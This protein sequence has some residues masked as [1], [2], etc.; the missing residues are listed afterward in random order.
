MKFRYNTTFTYEKSQCKGDDLD[1]SL[2]VKGELPQ[3]VEYLQFC[4]TIDKF[5]PV[6]H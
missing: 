6:L 4:S 3:D 5:A 1:P 2:R